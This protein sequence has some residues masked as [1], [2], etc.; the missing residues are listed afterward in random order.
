[1]ADVTYNTASFPALIATL[2]R[3]SDLSRRSTNDSAINDSAAHN[4]HFETI[5]S[6]RNNAPLV[7]LAYKERDPAE[8]TLWDMA[9]S[10]GLELEDIDSV[11]GAGGAPVEIYL[12][13]F[14][15]V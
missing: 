8:R 1:M 12:G 6:N 10:I 2:K 11:Q 3:L 15:R 9:R 5:T 4:L 14:V 13:R 7:L